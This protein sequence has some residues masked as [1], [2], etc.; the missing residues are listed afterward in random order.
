MGLHSFT[1]YTVILSS[2]VN[3]NFAFLSRGTDNTTFQLD[4]SASGVKLKNDNG[5]LWVRNANDNGYADVRC[6]TL[7]AETING[8][9]TDI[10][11]GDIT[12]GNL[13]VTGN[14]TMDTG[15][16]ISFDTAG[17][18]TLK[19]DGT[20]FN[21]NFNDN[22]KIDTGLVTG[23]T[24]ETAGQFKS[25]VAQGTA[26]I[27]VVSTT[28]CDNLNADLLDGQHANVFELIANKDVP[29]GYA[30]LDV[31]GNL[32]TTATA[33]DF[34]VNGKLTVVGAIDPTELAMPDNAPIYLDTAKT[35]GLSFSSDKNLID[36]SGTIYVPYIKSNEIDVTGDYKLNGAT[37]INSSGV[38]QNIT[39]L[40]LPTT[41]PS[42]PVNGS[43]YYDDDVSGLYIYS[44]S[45][46]GWLSV[47]LT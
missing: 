13:D 32:D 40:R 47:T 35:T 9:I 10:T 15:K 4:V 27:D 14:I 3:D 33:S 44:G 43:C 23:A 36:V 41:Q 8:N 45:A 20:H 21:F 12:V 16:T 7:T 1:P 39:D 5:N 25:T 2:Q 37:L 34:T 29:N 30:G 17:T 24:I 11:F 19:W 28:L 42:N 26:P 22:V 38:I 46:G 31:S 6:K 18:K